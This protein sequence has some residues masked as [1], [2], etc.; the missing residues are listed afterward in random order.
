MGRDDGRRTGVP[1]WSALPAV[2]TVLEVHA[3]PFATMRAVMAFIERL[4]AVS[5]VRDV[6]LDRW[7]AGRAVFVLRHH[8][9]EPLI[10]ALRALEDSSLTITLRQPH[11]VQIQIRP[12][13]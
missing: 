10:S 13:V 5:G 4:S 3:G 8:D 11:G 2:S 9:R 6:R 1:S 7:V 12:P